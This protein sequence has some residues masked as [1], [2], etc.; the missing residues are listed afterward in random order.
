MPQ[1]RACCNKRKPAPDFR[2][3]TIH[4]PNATDSAVRGRRLDA[5]LQEHPLVAPTKGGVFLGS[6][7]PPHVNI[8][9]KFK[10]TVEQT[11]V[12]RGAGFDSL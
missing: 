9:R 4:M 7:H 2:F 3:V 10:H 8:R 5:N 12:V 6:Q 11:R 1:Q